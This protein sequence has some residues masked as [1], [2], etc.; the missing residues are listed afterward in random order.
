ML[1]CFFVF[2]LE[3]IVLSLVRPG[4]VLSFFFWMDVASTLSTVMEIPMVMSGLLG[5]SI[6]SNTNSTKLAKLNQFLTYV[7]QEEHQEFHHEQLK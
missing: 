1:A 7:E 2:A 4:Y 3:I 5:I 6:F